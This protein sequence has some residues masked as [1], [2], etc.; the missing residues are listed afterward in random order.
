MVDLAGGPME[1]LVDLE[2]AH[3]S[4]ALR[5]GLMAGPVELRPSEVLRADLMAGPVGLH[6]SE[7]LRVDH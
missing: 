4:E 2:Q 1:D 7:V 3:P 5:V 6:P